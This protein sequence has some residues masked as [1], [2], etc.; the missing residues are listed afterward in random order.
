MPVCLSVRLWPAG[1]DSR[2]EKEPCALVL[3]D[4]KEWYRVALP[5]ELE[6]E[7]D[8]RFFAPQTVAS[9][10]ILFTCTKG[11]EQYLYQIMLYADTPVLVFLGQAV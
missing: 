11:N 9:D 3:F 2:P 8:I 6:N 4:G 7:K 10:R 1:A 5:D